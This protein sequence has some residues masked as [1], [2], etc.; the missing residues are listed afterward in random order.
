MINNIPCLN[1]PTWKYSEGRS[2]EVLP[3]N[4]LREYPLHGTGNIYSDFNNDADAHAP[5]NAL[6][7]H[8]KIQ[9]ISD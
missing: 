2:P 3:E 7:F 8:E 6:I 4:I 9:G 5:A 1:Y